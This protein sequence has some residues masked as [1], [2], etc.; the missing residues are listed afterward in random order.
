VCVCVVGSAGAGSDDEA[1]RQGPGDVQS[2]GDAGATSTSVPPASDADDAAA[3]AT[4][5]RRGVRR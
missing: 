2:G 3:A 4:S 5:D 1:D